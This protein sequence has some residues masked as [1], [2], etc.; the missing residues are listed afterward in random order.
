MLNAHIAEHSI[1]RFCEINS[2]MHYFLTDRAL[3]TALRICMQCVGV[4]ITNADNFYAPT[5]LSTLAHLLSSFRPFT[6]VP[7][8]ARYDILLTDMVN[9]GEP[10]T[11][12]TSLGMMDLGGAL[13]C[14]TLLRSSNIRFLYSLPVPTEPQHYHNADFHFIEKLLAYGARHYVEHQIL[15]NHNR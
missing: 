7:G 15:F 9:K 6:R 2:P 4:I 10:V 1:K 3:D 11:V 8:Y 12:E 13:I 5:F 14:A